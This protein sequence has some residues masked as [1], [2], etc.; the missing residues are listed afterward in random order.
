MELAKDPNVRW[1]LISTL[2]LGLGSGVLGSFA[3]LRKQSLMGDVLSHAALPGICIAFMLTGIKSIPLF[4]IGAFISCLLATFIIG[5]VTRYS[6]IKVDTA[7]AMVLSVFFAIG[8]VLLTQ[9]QHYRSGNA[10]GLDSFLFG[11]AAAMVQEDVYITMGTSIGL[12]IA[13][14]CLFKEFKLISFDPGFARGIGLPVGVLEQ[15]LMFLLV[16]AVVVGVESVGVVL[17]A[18]MLI[19]PAVAAR[20]WTNRLG[21]MV[22]LSGTFGA[23]SG[24]IGTL[25]S[26]TMNGLPSGPL[27][28]LSASLIFVVSLLIGPKKGLI[29]RMVIRNRAKRYLHE[30]IHQSA[31]V[32]VEE[33]NA[34]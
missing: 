20:Y 17:M 3:Y 9:I 8:I 21:V 23:I 2:L 24:V 30:G 5:A 29:S 34:S 28:V 6:R 26:T 7:F 33:G 12:I 31:R 19:S 13:C 27:T 15:I 4:F 10:S 18:A 16:V 32:A 22:I 11:Q 14:A 1:I 25:L